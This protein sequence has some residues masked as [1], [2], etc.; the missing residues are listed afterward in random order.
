MNIIIVSEKELSSGGNVILQGRRF[1][2]ITGVLGSRV[3][4]ILRVGLL[5]GKLGSGTI[6]A[7]NSGSLEMNITLDREPPAPLPVTLLIALPRPKTVK[8]VLMCATT[9]GIKKIYFMKTW[10]VEKSFWQS[11][12][13]DEKSLR[14]LSLLGL[15]QCGDTV[16]PEIEFRKR[17][18]P[19]VEDEIPGII[20]QSLPV[21]AHPRTGK[22]IESLSSMSCRHI[23]LAIGP[24]SGFIDYELK[25]F[26]ETGFYPVSLGPRILRVEHAVP[27]LLGS[28]GTVFF[29]RNPG[30]PLL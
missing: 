23:T 22:R 12:V 17:F 10:R 1:N 15:E 19:F 25:K 5:G 18:K 11:K 24:E 2:H 26:A 21:L 20:D 29:N 27:A 28:I 6:R 9:M 16:F 4:E 14:E 8:K 30:T 3:G 7:I 13:L